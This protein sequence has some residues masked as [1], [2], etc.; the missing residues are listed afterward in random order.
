MWQLQN[1]VRHYPWGS[2][3]V[4][5]ELLGSPSPADRPHA[6][7]WM[8]AHPDE[9]S[10]R[11]DGVPL[12]KAIASEPELLL[13]PEVLERFGVRLPFLMKVLAAEKPVS[14]QA[15]PTAEQAEAGFDP[16]KA[17]GFANRVLQPEDHWQDG[18]RAAL[19]YKVTDSGMTVA[20][21]ADHLVETENE[22]SSRSLVEPE[23]N[24]NASQHQSTSY[25][26]VLPRPFHLLALLL[27]DPPL[28]IEESDFA[29]SF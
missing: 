7:L 19:S 17:D 4:I 14:L 16:R 23:E 21:V 26:Q 9:P 3:T 28:A 20:V 18:T 8:G 5:P 10:V 22:Y 11:S 24:S 13:G 29:S 25:L 6:E 15:H 2:H 12:D 1:A 27:L